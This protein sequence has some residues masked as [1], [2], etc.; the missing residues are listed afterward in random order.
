[1]SK[2]Y[3]LLGTIWDM[4]AL[5]QKVDFAEKDID[6]LDYREERNLFDLQ[7]Y[8]RGVKASEL[9]GAEKEPKVDYI[10][11]RLLWCDNAYLIV[12][13]EP[14]A[15]IDVVREFYA[16]RLLQMYEVLASRLPDTKVLIAAGE[17]IRKRCEG[18]IKNTA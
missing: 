5:P 10:I 14:R 3:H 1:M 18:V 16:H 11:D 9:F 4:K 8:S 2:S 13:N 17:E 12:D 6:V 15:K 7:N